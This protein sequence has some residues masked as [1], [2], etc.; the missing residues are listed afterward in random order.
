MGSTSCPLC[1]AWTVGFE[2]DLTTGVI[3]WYCLACGHRWHRP[4][5][6]R[7]MNVPKLALYG[8]GMSIGLLGLGALVALKVADDCAKRAGWR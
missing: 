6:H 2:Y 3:T 8:A 7:P 5:N 4:E 1:G